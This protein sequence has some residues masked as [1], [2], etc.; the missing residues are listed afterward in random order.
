MRGVNV[1]IPVAVGM[2]FFT[3]SQCVTTTWFSEEDNEEA[4]GGNLERR[5]WQSLGGAAGKA[6][7]RGLFKLSTAG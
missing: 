6:N 3:E 5:C 4:E 7:K 2:R 1:G